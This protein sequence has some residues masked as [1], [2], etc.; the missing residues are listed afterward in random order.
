MMNMV[1]LLWRV[2][3]VEGR[4]R[5]AWWRLRMPFLGNND[6]GMERERGIG[7]IYIPLSDH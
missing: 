5:R 4:E 1:L 7:I 2:I 6:D 3:L